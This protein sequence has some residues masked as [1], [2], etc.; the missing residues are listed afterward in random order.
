MERSEV[1]IL[2]IGGGGAGLTASMLLSTM[3]VESLLVSSLPT[4]SLLP[5][6][7]ILNQRAMEIMSDAG[8][9]D[10]IYAIGTPPEQMSHTAFYAGMAGHPDAGRMLH[11]QESWGGGGADPDWVAAS[12]FL[13]TNLP[14]IRLEP[15]LR[16]RA[17]ELAPGAV[18]FHHEAI[19][20][21]Q[22]PDGV[23]VVV[24]DLDKNEDYE[25]FARYVLACDGGRTM[26]PALGVEMIGLTD[27]TRTATVHMS[28]DLSAFAGDPDVLLRWIWCPSVAKLAVMAPMGPTRWG[29]DSEEW[30]C[31]LNY[32]ADDERAFDDDAVIEDMRLALGIGDIPLDVHL[33]TR[34]TIGG[35]VASHFKVGRVFMVGDA[36]HR[37]PP[38]GALGLTS[39]MHDVQNL[40]WKLALTLRG[41]AGEAL[42]ESYEPERR[43][44][45]QRNVDR[46]LENALAYLV[47]ADTLGLS[48]ARATPDERWAAMARLWSDDPADAE[49][50]RSA[51]DLMAAQSQE[52]H[53]HDVEYGYRH[54]SRAV[55]ADGSHEPPPT[56]FRIFHPSTRPGSP[57]PHAWL[58]NAHG[59]RFSTLTLV[60]LDGFALIAGE[61]GEAW[62]QAANKVAAERGITV[63]AVSVGHAAGD[64]LDP[65]LRWERVREITP[66]GAILVRPD[67]CIAWRSMGAGHDEAA[68]LGA[69]F[70]AILSRA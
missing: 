10:R 55:V 49:H 54:R 2:I 42:L 38:T 31:H 62:V 1:P 35:V 44:V 34:W 15:L 69:A 56:N 58:E 18:R 27:L 5:K 11:K 21:E 20:F 36:A 43:P 40:C 52:F 14:Q 53:E 30:V 7:H 29:G 63:N 3:G 46:S 64:L 67:R 33:V 45:D 48:D 19:S 16:E 66:D 41:V 39:A 23:L 61:R 22:Q 25:V 28:A 12:P 13:S 17:E 68:E 65:R 26:G 59:E 57:L 50:R 70:D 9:A 47:M 37:H 24:R 4:T 6:A 32:E 51:R 8:V 60:P